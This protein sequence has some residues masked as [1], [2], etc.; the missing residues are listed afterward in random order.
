LE[1]SRE[2]WSN[3]LLWKD[4]EIRTLEVP[5]KFEKLMKKEGLLE[6]FHKLGYSH[7]REYIRWVSEA[8]KEETR[9]RRLEKAI[10]MLKHGVKT[11]G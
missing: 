5:A 7:R 4:D 11:P 8:K 2:T 6:F 3:V 9:V 1:S 10:A